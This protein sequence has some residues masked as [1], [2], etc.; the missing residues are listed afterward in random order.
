M[1]VEQRAEVGTAKAR[2]MTSRERFFA[3]IDGKPTDVIPVHN[4][5]FSSEVAS[6]LIGREAYIGGGIQQWREATA[7]WNGP[8]AHEEFLE[9]SFEDAIEVARV[10]G[11]DL[12]RYNYWRLN[13]KPAD[14][15]DE[16]TFKY[17]DPHSNRW[18]VR[19][20]SALA[21][22]FEQLSSAGADLHLVISLCKSGGQ[23]E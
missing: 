4:L 19:Q 5:G 13:E 6:H 15:I 9:R 21:E 12:I 7:L 1:G 10:C 2:T 18:H 16:Y 11:H 8:R 14:R 22:L 17:V 23:V 3:A 20:Y